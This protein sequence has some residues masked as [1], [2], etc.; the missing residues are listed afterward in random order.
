MPK[1]A[2]TTHVRMENFRKPEHPVERMFIE[3][4]SPRAFSNEMLTEEETFTLFEAAR[5][6]PSCFNDQPW[7]FLY[8]RR[9]TPEWDVFV[10][11]LVDANKVWAKNASLLVVFIAH[12]NFEMNGK[13][14]R[15]HSFDCGSAWMSF[16]L[17]AAQKGWVAHGMAGFDY[18][19]ARKILKVPEDYSVEAMAAA[20]KPGRR[21]DLPDEKLRQREVPSPRKPLK[22]L[23]FKGQ[24]P[25]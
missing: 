5:W 14:N 19:K 2:E 16:A 7:R 10:D 13:P 8:A 1:L 3:R 25:S 18:D 6:A 23:V 15:T 17:Q 24:F 9:G 12:K 21:E 4:W 11:L 22:D 20:G